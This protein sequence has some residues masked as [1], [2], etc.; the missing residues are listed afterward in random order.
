[1]HLI[2]LTK[3]NIVFDFPQETNMRPESQKSISQPANENTTGSGQ[4]DMQKTR[5]TTGV[6]AKTRLGLPQMSKAKP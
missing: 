4:N 3:L 2:Y 1:M 5:N 6:Q